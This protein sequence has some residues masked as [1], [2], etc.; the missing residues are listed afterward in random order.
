MILSAIE[1]ATRRRSQSPSSEDVRLRVA[2]EMRLR[3]SNYYP[4]RN[5]H[6]DVLGGMAMLIGFVPSYHML[7]LALAAVAEIDC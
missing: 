3:S 1:T 6:C 7:Q 2:I 4:V 5:V